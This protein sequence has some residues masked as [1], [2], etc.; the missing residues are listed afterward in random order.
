MQVTYN[1]VMYQAMYWNSG[2]AP[3]GTGG[4]WQRIVACSGTPVLPACTATAW[5]R[6]QTY[7]AGVRVS[8]QGAEFQSSWSSTGTTPTGA[9]GNPW[10][11]LDGC[12][13]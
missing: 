8:Y 2:T 10:K 13:P 11:W 1:G 9:N 12:T 7:P 3:G 5:S 6:T 4:P